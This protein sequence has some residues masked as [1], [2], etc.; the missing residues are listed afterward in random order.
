MRESLRP[1]A[2]FLRV[3]EA[4]R[5]PAKAYLQPPNSRTAPRN[6]AEARECAGPWGRSVEVSRYASGQCSTG[7]ELDH[8]PVELIGDL[9][10]G[11]MTN[12]L[13]NNQASVAEVLPQLGRGLRRYRAIQF[14]PQQESGDVP[15]P[16]HHGFEVLQV[17]VPG[18]QNRGLVAEGTGMVVGFRVAFQRPRRNATCVAI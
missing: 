7:E 16:R 1:G 14:A 2:P 12:T 11:Q 3:R 15:D 13:E 8:R 10:I 9:L 6:F 18:S 5:S 17:A 4:R